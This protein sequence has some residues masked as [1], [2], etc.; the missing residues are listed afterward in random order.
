MTRTLTALLVLGTLAACSPR[1]MADRMSRRTAETVVRPIVDD[2]LTEPQ[3]LG[4]TRCIVTNARPD[5]VQALLRYVGVYAG[6]S[7]VATV[8]GILSRPETQGCIRGSGL[9]VPVL[10]G[11]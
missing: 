6:S 9:P 5:E 8:A 2:A 10:G 3:A 4:V 7:T 11:L 1:D